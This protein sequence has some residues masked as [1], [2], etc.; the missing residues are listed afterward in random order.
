MH[1]HLSLDTSKRKRK[2]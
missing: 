1:Y 2:K